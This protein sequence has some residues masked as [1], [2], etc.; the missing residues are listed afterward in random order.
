M[1]VCS[2]FVQ[3]AFKIKKAKKKTNKQKK[4][5]TEWTDTF[6]V[7]GAFLFH[8]NV[9]KM[10][11]IPISLVTH[12]TKWVDVMWMNEKHALRNR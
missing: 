1:T 4:Q 2:K 12:G 3:S 8:D 7:L 10:C 5:K 9:T 6:D 11:F